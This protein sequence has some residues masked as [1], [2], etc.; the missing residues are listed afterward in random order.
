[1]N[2]RDH[3]HS[4]PDILGGKPVVK[5]IRISVELILEYLSEGAPISE[6]LD[7][8]PSLKEADVLAAIAFSHDLLVK[9]A[10]AARREAA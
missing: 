3:I 6:V 10:A 7:G 4:N 2:W 8:Y 1:M 9:E 5:G